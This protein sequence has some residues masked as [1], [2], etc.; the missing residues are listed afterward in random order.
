MVV[1]LFVCFVCL[2]WVVDLCDQL[3]RRSCLPRLSFLS[4]QLHIGEDLY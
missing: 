2:G 4:Q 3:L 1:A